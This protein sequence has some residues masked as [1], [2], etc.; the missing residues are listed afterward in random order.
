M[1]EKGIL[2]LVNTPI[3]NLSDMTPRAVETLQ[4]VDLVAAEDTRRTLQLL[5]HFGIKKPLTSYYEH[6]KAEKGPT[7]LQRLLEGQSV[8][9]VSDAGSPAISDPGEDLVRLCVEHDVTVTAVPGA[10]ALVTALVCSGLPTGR[11]SFEGF[12]SVNKRKR[13]EHL[14]ELADS[15]Y[16]MIFYE[17]P[18]KLKYTLADLRDTFGGGRRIVLARELTKKHEEFK[19]CTLDEALRLYED[20]SPRGE[21]VLVVE[22]RGDAPPQTDEAPELPPEQRY[23]QLLDGGIPSKEAMKQVAKERGVSKRDIYQLL[24]ETDGKRKPDRTEGR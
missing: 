1:A 6:N 15:T 12:L 23:K 11:F 17:A 8:A 3:G 5:N 24:L 21:Y 20:V 16:T 13:R 18:H 19:R 9:L 10:T 14:A 7:L 2:Y 4:A 22:G